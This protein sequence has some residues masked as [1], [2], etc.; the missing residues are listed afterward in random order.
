MALEKYDILKNVRLSNELHE[1]LEDEA[2]YTGVGQ[3]GTL[4]RMILL[5]RLRLG[6][7]EP[8]KRATERFPILAPRDCPRINIGLSTNL[9]EMV[10]QAASVVS[11]G[12]FAGLV[13]AVLAEWAV[14]RKKRRP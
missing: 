7:L 4:I 13:H 9:S 14:K 2:N 3:I 6:N 12:Q 8:L 5:Q 10:D 1:L 11:D